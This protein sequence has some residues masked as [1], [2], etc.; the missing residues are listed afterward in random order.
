MSTIIVFVI[1]TFCNTAPCNTALV[2]PV[3]VSVVNS[4]IAR[5]QS[6]YTTWSISL[7]HVTYLTIPQ[8]VMEL[9]QQLKKLYGIY[10]RVYTRSIRLTKTTAAWNEVA[11]SYYRLRGLYF[12]AVIFAATMC[13]LYR[14]Y[15]L[16]CYCYNC[17][18]KQCSIKQEMNI[19]VKVTIMVLIEWE[20]GKKS[21]RKRDWSEWREKERQRKRLWD[22][23]KAR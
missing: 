13:I 9:Y 20:D 5:D 16:F 8:W 17:D 3:N 19:K 7:Y 6:H 14:S 22:R 15:E 10:Y 21:E 11:L 1:V 2:I 4:S 18:D 12:V 23:I